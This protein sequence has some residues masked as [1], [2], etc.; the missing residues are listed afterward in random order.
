MTIDQRFEKLLEH[1]LGNRISIS[2]R[3]LEYAMHMFVEHIKCDFDPCNPDCE[4]QYHIPLMGVP[5]IPEI[6]LEDGYWTLTR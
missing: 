1:Q 6:G 4:A 2:S 3:A 5:D